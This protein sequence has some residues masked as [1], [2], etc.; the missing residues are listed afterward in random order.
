MEKIKKSEEEYM[1]KV[2]LSFK[3]VFDKVNENTLKQKRD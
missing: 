1:K 2:T 3:A